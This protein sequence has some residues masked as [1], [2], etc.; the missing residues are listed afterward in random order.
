MEQKNSNAPN[1]RQA[2]EDAVIR[3]LKI[4]P[5]YYNQFLRFTPEWQQRFLDFCCSKKTLP[6]TYD[7]FF[8]RIFHPDIHAGRLSA[9][10][11]AL[12]GIPV[13]VVRLLP[14]TENMLDGGALLIMDI[15]VELEDGALANVEVQKIPY[16]FPG[17]RI[18]CYSADLL[19]RQYS[20]VK[21]EVGNAFKYK[22]LKKVITIVIY[23]K[24][25][26]EFHREGMHYLHRGKCVFDTGL[27]IELLQEYCLLALDVF[28]E[29]PY[30]KIENEQ[31]AWIAFLATDSLE[32]ARQLSKTYPWLETLYE[33]M[34]EYLHKPEEVLNMFSDALKIMDHNTVQYMIEQ[35][36]QQL[37]EIHEELTTA[38]SR[39]S[40]TQSQLSDAQNRL[41]NTQ[42]QLS[43]TQDQLSNAQDQLSNT[44]DQLAHAQAQVSEAEEKSI[45]SIVTLCRDLGGTKETAITQLQEKLQLNP[46]DAEAAVRKYWQG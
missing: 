14:N 28:K 11:S 44:Q 27:E 16:S 6:V 10:I 7:P 33:E 37:D 22:D 38:Q 12:L 34:A 1:L 26:S 5:V 25:T 18:S 40:E 35:Q 2:N 30:P 21:G 3:E 45:R 4:N 39:L 43:N 31:T 8:K 29:S 9:L 32:Q 20:R 13:K 23:E 46:D 17:E 36:Q 15:L 41:S 24:S 19:L 42:D